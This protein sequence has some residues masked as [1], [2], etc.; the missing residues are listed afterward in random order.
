MA[1]AVD[2]TDL[3]D[4]RLV[5]PGHDAVAQI[6]QSQLNTLP[7]P[8]PV[9][10]PDTQTVQ[11]GNHTGQWRDDEATTLFRKEYWR[12]CNPLETSTGTGT[13]Q[14]RKIQAIDVISVFRLYPERETNSQIRAGSPVGL[15]RVGA[16]AS[17]I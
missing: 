15:W 4:A 17:I 12:R 5:W 9:E 10:Y 6:D 11:L 13:S 3:G 2:E 1:V 8:D 7:I 16:C 14:Q